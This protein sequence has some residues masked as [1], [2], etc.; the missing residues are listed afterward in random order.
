MFKL[1]K[2]KM[3]M[4]G[5]MI[6][7]LLCY[8]IAAQAML[9]PSFMSGNVYAPCM[10]DTVIC[11]VLLYMSACFCAF[12]LEISHDTHQLTCTY[13]Y[14]HRSSIIVLLQPAHPPDPLSAHFQPQPI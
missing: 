2:M 10:L 9:R 11:Q 6:Y 12:T 1:V 7:F 5:C 14:C 13:H 3:K 4:K 8:L